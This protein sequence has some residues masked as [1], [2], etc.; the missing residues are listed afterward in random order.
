MSR[1][2]HY[3]VAGLPDLLLDDSKLQI[4]LNEFRELL[5][6]NLAQPD[7]ELV[8]TYFYRFDNKNILARL[9]DP[10]AQ[11]DGRGNLSPDQLDLVF[12]A[13]REGSFASDF[14]DIPPYI[15]QFLAAY[16]QDSPIFE[17]KAWE[18]QLSELYYQ[19]ATSVE[20][21]FIG[22]WYEFEKNM[23][24]LVT[25]AQCRK[26]NIPVDNQLIG[27]GEILEKLQRSNARDFGLDNDFP[28]L[29]EILKATEEQDLKDFE[30]KM[31]RIRWAFLDEEVFFYYFSVERIF[32]FLIKL[33]IIE[34]W[35]VLDKETGQKLFNELLSN[36]EAT[37]EFP[38]EFKLK[39]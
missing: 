17:N 20:N 30:L 13:A 27:T 9:Q 3:L 34:R 2:Y 21:Q 16:T 6:E 36:M 32:S 23:A 8:N 12:Q 38:E 29:E 14:T 25:A 35:M 19:Y 10:E 1:E 28:A 7:L 4:D 33:A 24:N 31:D 26:Y 5:E 22:S 15:D 37:Y 18:L 39:K 11:P